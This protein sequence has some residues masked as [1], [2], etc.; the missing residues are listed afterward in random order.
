M[1]GVISFAHP[2][3]AALGA[4][5]SRGL[6]VQALNAAKTNRSRARVPARRPRRR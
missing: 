3:V 2:T 1:N 5:A 6:L 4:L